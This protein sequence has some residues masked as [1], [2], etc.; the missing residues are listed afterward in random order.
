MMDRT[1]P[2]AGGS[3]D[4]PDLRLSW[5]EFGLLR[6]LSRPELT[7]DEAATLG[8]MLPQCRADRW[9]TLL[10]RAADHGV[11][12]WWQAHLAAA[13][14]T[15]AA[16]DRLALRRHCD[17]LALRVL[18]SDILH[19]R[20][21]RDL[22]TG[23]D[24]A[25]VL[26]KGRAIEAR[27]YPAGVPRPAADLDLL[28]RPGQRATVEAALLGHGFLPGHL[29]ASGH[30]QAWS[31][32][33]GTIDLHHTLL[34]PLRFPAAVGP[35]MGAMSDRVAPGPSGCLELDPLDQ[36]AHLIVH[37]TW[38]VGADLRHL[39]DLVQWVRRA[40]VPPQPA[41]ARIATWV[42][43]RAGAA[44]SRALLAFAP[45]LD[46][47]WGALDRS[48]A[49]DHADALLQSVRQHRARATRKPGWPWHVLFETALRVDDPLRFGLRWMAR[50]VTSASAHARPF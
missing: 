15:L 22:A 24:A 8:T 26:I 43:R 42:A 49:R 20:V 12:L 37:L 38:G 19:A 18:R 39:G 47:A 10:G 36:T 34:C 29:A 14:F 25:C 40:G 48:D 6:L 45:D 2:S 3:P 33:D 13:D 35:T 41:L 21:A 50:R 17:A 16:N 5:A 1:A 9:P 30:E 7:A 27:V 28:V 32:P 46:R 44:A 4:R 11:A 31:A 23:R